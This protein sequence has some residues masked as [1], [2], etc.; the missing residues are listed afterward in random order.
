MFKGT[1]SPLLKQV[2]TYNHGSQSLAWASVLE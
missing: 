2:K 1:N